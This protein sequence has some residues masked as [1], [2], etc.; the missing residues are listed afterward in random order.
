MTTG[1][2]RFVKYLDMGTKFFKLFINGVLPVVS[3]HL[4]GQRLGAIK[5]WP[6]IGSWFKT[7]TSLKQCNIIHHGH[8]DS[9]VQGANIGPTWVLSAPGGS[10]VGPMNL[11]VWAVLV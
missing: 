11:A 5:V 4:L 7:L 8:P 3:Y 6:H 1:V 10:H 9:K 2:G